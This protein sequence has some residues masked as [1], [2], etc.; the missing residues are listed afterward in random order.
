MS[1]LMSE[2]GLWRTL[3]GRNLSEDALR[4]AGAPAADRDG[5]RGHRGTPLPGDQ[6]GPRPGVRSR[7]VSGD[8]EGLE[9]EVV[10]R[11]GFAFHPVP[12]RKLS[13]KPSLESLAALAAL[14][15]GR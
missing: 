1:G 3:P 8:V 12:S 9:A 15:W 11:S 14:G 2:P 4:D 13:R 5:R 10:P 6:P 7:G